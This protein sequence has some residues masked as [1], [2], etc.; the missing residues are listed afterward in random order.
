M[1]FAK[2]FVQDALV[3]AKVIQNDS[4]KWVVGFTDDFGVDQKNPRVEV[5]IMEVTQ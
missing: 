4:Q 1:A 3:K 5:E 2:K